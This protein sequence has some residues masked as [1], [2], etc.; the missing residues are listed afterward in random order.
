MSLLKHCA[1]GNL[2][3]IKAELRNR[4]SRQDKVEIRDNHHWN[5]LH[6][7]VRSGNVDCIKYLLTIKELDTTA[8][9]FEG[10]TAAF[11]T[12]NYPIRFKLARV[13]IPT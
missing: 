7:A 11:I 1:D 4:R 3:R 8:E 6:H 10:N 9:T 12:T 2:A 5:C 13:S